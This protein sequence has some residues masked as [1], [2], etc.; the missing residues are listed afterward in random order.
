MLLKQIKRKNGF[1]RSW[2]QCED[3]SKKEGSL[4]F[5]FK[6]ERAQIESTCCCPRKDATSQAQSCL[7]LQMNSGCPLKITL[8]RNFSPETT[9][10]M[11]PMYLILL[12]ETAMP[13][14]LQELISTRIGYIPFGLP[15]FLKS[16]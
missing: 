9:Y 15:W 6:K 11:N 3:E 13:M 12:V 8:T 2:N 14:G 5:V 1:R 7:R 16:H 10:P 4:E